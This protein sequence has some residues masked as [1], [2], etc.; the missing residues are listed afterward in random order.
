MTKHTSIELASIS[1]RAFAFGVDLF[2]GGALRSLL[3]ALNL[4][5]LPF[6]GRGTLHTAGIALITLAFLY[7]C[8]LP[9]YLDGQTPGK[10]LFGIRVVSLTEK[11][12][13]VRRLFTRNWLGY[14]CSSIFLGTGFL[15]ATTNRQQQTWHD[16][17]AETVVIRARR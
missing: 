6:G 4:P 12:L 11:P 14:L 10:L 9:L 3:E 5:D 13:T 2:I 17:V 16:I 15:W 1:A 8:V 7:F